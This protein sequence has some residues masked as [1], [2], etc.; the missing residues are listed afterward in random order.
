MGDKRIKHNMKKTRI[1]NVWSGMK[2]RCSDKNNKNYGIKGITVCE[3]WKEFVNFK[4]WAFSNGYKDDLTIDRIDNSKGYCPEN[5]RWTDRITQARNKSTNNK[6]LTKNGIITAPE[7][8]EKNNISYTTI[9]QRIIKLKKQNLELTEENIMNG[10]EPGEKHKKYIII[11]NGA[12]LSVKE[13]SQL[14]S[15]NEKT[16]HA[17]LKRKNKKIINSNEIKLKESL[18]IKAGDTIKT[19]KSYSLEKKLCFATLYYRAKKIS[20]NRVIFE[21]NELIHG[22]R[23]KS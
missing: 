1:Y 18:K 22:W 11:H 23:C 19:L 4:D 9:K 2:R 13:F 21:E 14:K 8:A 3:E 15:I 6:I 12:E 7:L 17:F 10:F 5:C 20:K 16:L